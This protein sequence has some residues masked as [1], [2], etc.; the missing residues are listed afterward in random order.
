M[1]APN[2]VTYYMLGSS[3]GIIAIVLAGLRVAVA[4]ARWE[5]SQRIATLR[6]ATAL[7]VLWFGVALAL[8]S[9][10]VFRGATDRPPTIEFGIF[11]PIVIGLAWLWR[12]TT[13]MRLIDA[14]PQSWLVAIQFYRVLGV[15][16][17]LM[18]AQG[19]MP[20]LFALPAGS[21]DVAVGLLAPVVAIAYARGVAGREVLV[22]GWNL[23]GLADLTVAITTGFLTAPS[24]F[25]MF[26]LNAPNDLISAYPLV[27]VPV[28]GVPLAALLHVASLVKLSRDAEHTAATVRA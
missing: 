20:S 16:F 5:D 9:A 27:L 25:Q 21:G 11:V 22:R 6:T 2:Y 12:S 10:E 18:N 8:S 24:P 3:I 14:I 15:I 13:A 23:L 7:L 4:R 19:R 26:S 17:L 1:N 28:F